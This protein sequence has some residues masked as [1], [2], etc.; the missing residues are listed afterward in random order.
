MSTG[1]ETVV[2]PGRIKIRLLFAFL[3]GL[4]ALIGDAAGSE[5]GGGLARIFGQEAQLTPADLALVEKGGIAARV[6][7]TGDKSEVL[8][9]ALMRVKAKSD[10]VKDRLRNVDSWRQ[11]PWVMQIGAVGAAPA[12]ADMQA[13]TLDP[14]GVK[15]L[16]RCRVNKCDVRFSREAIE[17]FR[18][19]VDWKSPAS[20]DRANA[21][22]REI[23]TAYLSSYLSRGNEA[24][25]LYENNDDPV[26]I[27]DSL[28]TLFHR[29]PSLD[30]VAPDV[31]SHLAQFP[32]AGPEGA[33]EVVY[34]MK[35]RFWRVN[36]ISLN[37]TTLVDRPTESGRLIL[38]VTKQLY[39]DHYFESSLNLTASMEPPGGGVYILSLNRTRADIRKT[40]F[41]WVERK[42]VNFLVK[43]RL[44]SQFGQLRQ[45]LE[46]P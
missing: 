21:L 17:R 7:G 28:N 29:S 5:G 37:H 20:A 32:K 12:I 6:L 14:G 8:S 11:Y 46:A 36:V 18:K 40:G 43:R 27:H 15:D 23:L 31:R 45:A 39:A 16:S 41:D 3:F 35:E 25:F 30:A 24:L 4:C 44:E 10:R 42:L 26:R 2:A 1:D 19:E 13:L 22:F 38:A 34:W 9:I 33:Q